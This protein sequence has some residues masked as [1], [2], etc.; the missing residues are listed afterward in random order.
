MTGSKWRHEARRV[1]EEALRE[2]RPLGLEGKALRAFVSARYPFGERA[3]HPYKIWCSEVGKQ[4]DAPHTVR[5][6]VDP[7]YW[8]NL[9]RGGQR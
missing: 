4:L 2:A 1:I 7:D 5:G 8:V 3:M 6:Q 9:T